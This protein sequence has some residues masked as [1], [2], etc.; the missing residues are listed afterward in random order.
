MFKL[1]KKPTEDQVEITISNKTVIRV[2]FLVVGAILFLAA[3]QRASYALI[4]VFT[5]FILALALNS[6]VQWIARHMPG[7]LKGK[8]SVATGVSFLIVIL[9][10]AGFMASIVPPLVK[11]TESFISSAPQLLDDTKDRDSQLGGFIRQYRLEGQVERATQQISGNL[12]NIGSSAISSLGKIGSSIFAVLTILALTFMMLIE[13]PRTVAFARE[14]IPGEKR[15]HADTIAEDMYRVIKGYVNGQ[16]TLAA[17]AALL[18]VPIFFILG[19]SYPIGLM[20]VV[21]IAGLI[22]MI[23]HTIG[24]IIV[25]IVAL[26]TSPFAAL[27]VLAYYILYQQIENYIIQPRVQSN[28]TNMSPLLVF[29]SVVIGVSFGGLFGGLFAIPIAGCLRILV[30]DYLVNHAYISNT[31]T[32]EDTATKAGAK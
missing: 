23:G 16:V 21:F 29:M 28:S 15:K 5:S 27:I 7:T 13:G 18:I 4:L 20:V 8:R 6:P 19:I 9:V 22:P 11:Q 30:L 31:P 26:F 17:I 1:F 2:L 32:I 10:F 3:L 14:L 25:T 12:Q 24:A